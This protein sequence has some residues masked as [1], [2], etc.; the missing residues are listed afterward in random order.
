MNTLR[1]EIADRIE[2]LIEAVAEDRLA[3]ED[4]SRSDLAAATFGSSWRR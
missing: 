3:H 2:R 4:Y 1:K